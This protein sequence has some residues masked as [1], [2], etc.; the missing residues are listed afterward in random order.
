MVAALADVGCAWYECPLPETDDAAPELARLR[1]RANAR[2][3]ILAGREEGVSRR[4]FESYAR[5]GAYDV[6]MPDVKYI[7]SVQEMLET[8]AALARHGVR[9]SP[10]NHTGPVGHA[11]SLAVA[12]AAEG[13]DLLEMQ[14][15][16]TEHFDRIV[17]PACPQPTAG[18]LGSAARAGLGL[19]LDPAGLAALPTERHD[20]G[21]A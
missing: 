2:G 1:S 17:A 18:R 20:A 13:C 21:T 3:M 5:A 6:M 7:G 19:G 16:E 10:H 11:A 9:V 15:D 12:L 14:F 4:S 8:A